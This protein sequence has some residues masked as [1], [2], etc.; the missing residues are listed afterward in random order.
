MN[1]WFIYQTGRAEA[2]PAQNKNTAEHVV[3]DVV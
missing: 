3:P 2:L 1:G